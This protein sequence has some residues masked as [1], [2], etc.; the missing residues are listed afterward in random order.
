LDVVISGGRRNF[1]LILDN[2]K[3]NINIEIWAFLPK[4]AKGGRRTGVSV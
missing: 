2:Y 1:I 4:Q 3:R